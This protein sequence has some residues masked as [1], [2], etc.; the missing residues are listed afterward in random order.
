M[1]S[2]SAPARRMLIAYD[3]TSIAAHALRQAAALLKAE[4]VEIIT[5]WEPMTRTNARAASMT[6]S[7][8]PAYTGEDDT[9][10]EHAR[11]VCEEG[12]E[13]AES[14]GLSVQ[15]HIVEH[16]GNIAQAIADAA[17]E[18]GVDVIVAGTRGISGVKSWFSNSTA[19]NVLQTANCPVFV[20]PSS[21][22]ED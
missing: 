3:G 15:A 21:S 12:I 10:Y 18:L 2:S 22:D 4:A 8:Q 11:N 1:N 20:V 17:D 14:L 16:T 6:G 13:L 7:H 5:A 19:A 9:A